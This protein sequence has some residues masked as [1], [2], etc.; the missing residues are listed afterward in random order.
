LSRS[1]IPEA[2]MP[3]SFFALSPIQFN[4]HRRGLL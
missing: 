1:V 3:S 4:K 2:A